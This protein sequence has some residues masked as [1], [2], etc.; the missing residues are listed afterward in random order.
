MQVSKHCADWVEISLAYQS[1][2]SQFR[3]LL[4]LGASRFDLHRQKAVG[5]LRVRFTVGKRFAGKLWRTGIQ[6]ESEITYRGNGGRIRSPSVWW[7]ELPVQ[8]AGRQTS[9]CQGLV[10]FFLDLLFGLRGGAGAG[11]WVEQAF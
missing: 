3:P 1:T 5:N 11:G 4:L 6:L 10:C 8:Y 9:W 7:L 2:I